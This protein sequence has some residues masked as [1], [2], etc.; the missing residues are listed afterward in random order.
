MHRVA[1]ATLQIA[2]TV[3]VET[4]RYFNIRRQVSAYV[5]KTKTHSICVFRVKKPV[6]MSGSAANF[7]PVWFQRLITR[8][9][10]ARVIEEILGTVALGN[11]KN[12]PVLMGYQILLR[13]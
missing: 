1:D 5:M 8:N 9:A 2:E 12:G 6:A 10:I 11:P 7:C 3:Y 13:I 4:G